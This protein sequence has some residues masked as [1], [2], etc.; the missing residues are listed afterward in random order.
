ME[1]IGKRDHHSGDIAQTADLLCQTR[2]AD[3]KRAFARFQSNLVRDLPNEGGISHRRDLHLALTAQYG[4]AAKDP[5]RQVGIGYS[6]L[7]ATGRRFLVHLAIFPCHGRLIDVNVSCAPNAVG[8]ELFPRA[9]QNNIPN[10][11]VVHTHL[12]D[13]SIPPHPITNMLTFLIQT[14]KSGFTAVFR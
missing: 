2:Q 8:R 3:L 11:N 1:Q 10:D 5:I 12:T 9:D 6:E 13:D 7:A 4:T 14:R